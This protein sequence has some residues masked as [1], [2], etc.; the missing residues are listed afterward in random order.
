MDF[1]HLPDHR[2]IASHPR[3]QPML[4]ETIIEA[5]AAKHATTKTEVTRDIHA[6]LRAEEAL[7]QPCDA[8]EDAGY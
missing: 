8:L 5:I 2:E 4:K 1:L 7:E 3:E 6:I